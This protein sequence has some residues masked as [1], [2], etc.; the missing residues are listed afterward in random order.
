MR[1]PAFDTYRFIGSLVKAGFTDKQ[2]KALSEFQQENIKQVLEMNVASK[3]DIYE[4]DKKLIRL[5]GKI[6]NLEIDLRNH[7]DKVGADLGTRIDKVSAD[8]G[9]R[10]DKGDADL[11]AR[12]DK[13]SVEVSGKFTLVYWMFGFTLTCLA[14]IMIKLY[15]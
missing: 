8:L 6:E 5:E 11:G 14:S 2:A 10:I 1:M 7:I 12:I 13:F 4:V 9:S 15:T 3:E